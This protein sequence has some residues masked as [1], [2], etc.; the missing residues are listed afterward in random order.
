MKHL[1]NLEVFITKYNNTINFLV[2]D[3]YNKEIRDDIK[4]DLL[5]FMCELHESLSKGNHIPNKIDSYVFISLKN[6]RNKILQKDIYR[7]STHYEDSIFDK[8]TFIS[9]DNKSMK[10]NEIAKHINK[11]IEQC[12]S[13]NEQEL[14]NKYFYENQKK[15][16]IGSLMGIT[17]QAVSKKI[18][19]IVKKIQYYYR[20]CIDMK[21]EK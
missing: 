3:V 17:Q 1:P 20:K 15:K 19:S 9:D 21:D 12:L 11:I 18:K 13:V 2:N 6:K 4:Q 7:E 14:I 10:N 8:I 16:E 5:M